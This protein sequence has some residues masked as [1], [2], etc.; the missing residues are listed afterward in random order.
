MIEFVTPGL[1]VTAITISGQKKVSP[2]ACVAVRPSIA[3]FTAPAGMFSSVKLPFASVYT[4]AS[5]WPM[6]QTFAWAI[7][8]RNTS[9]PVWMMPSGP[10]RM[11]SN[12]IGSRST[13]GS[14]TR[15]T[16]FVF[17]TAAVLTVVNVTVREPPA[18][19]SPSASR[20]AP[21]A[22]ARIL[23]PSTVTFTCVPP[24]MG[25]VGIRKA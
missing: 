13:P 9:S 4:N 11:S 19:P 24:G 12:V 3:T 16:S 23:E 5:S 2:S 18:C 21:S 1:S 10:R 14:T 7:G 8:C 6:I 17:A 25:V 15:P 20:N 22:F